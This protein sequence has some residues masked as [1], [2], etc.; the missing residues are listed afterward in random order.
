MANLDIRIALMQNNI[1]H[2]MFAK[3]L[4]I[5]EATLSRKLREE[6]SHD[7]KQKMMETIN[8]IANR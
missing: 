6:L 5:A 2:F 3:E 7:E 4:G 8:R 1:K